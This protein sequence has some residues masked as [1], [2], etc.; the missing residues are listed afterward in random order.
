MGVSTDA[1]FVNRERLK[2]LWSKSEE[3]ANH[4]QVSR[5]LIS[6]TKVESTGSELQIDK[7]EHAPRRACIAHK[8]LLYQN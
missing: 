2:Y 7:L 8:S 1:H 5:F 6:T 4:R 3:E